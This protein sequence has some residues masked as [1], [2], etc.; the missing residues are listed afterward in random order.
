M[1]HKFLLSS[2]GA[3]GDG[4]NKPILQKK[5]IKNKSEKKDP[6]KFLEHFKEVRK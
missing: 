6:F 1:N 2:L 5:I 4:E 3:E